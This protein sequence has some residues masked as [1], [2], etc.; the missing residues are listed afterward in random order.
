MRKLTGKPAGLHCR[1]CG[2]PE[3]RRRDGEHSVCA[4][5]GGNRRRVSF[6]PALSDA[7]DG[8]AAGSRTLDDVQQE[9]FDVAFRDITE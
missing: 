8:Y 3:N 4:H 5:C 9:S 6:G 1:D 7:I 2:E